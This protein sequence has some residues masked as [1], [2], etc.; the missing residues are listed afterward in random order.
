MASLTQWTWVWVNSGRLWWTGRPG[1]LRFMGSQRVGHG[2][3][4]ELTELRPVQLCSSLNIFWHFL[5]WD[6]KENW[7]VPVLWP[8]LSFPNLLEYWEQNFH[9]T[10]LRILNS[11]AGI[12]S[13]PLALFVV[14]LPK[15][16][17]TSHST[18]SGSRWVITPLWSSGS[19]RSRLY[20]FSVYYCHLVFISCAFVRCTASVLYC[21][22]RWMNYSFGISNFLEEISSLSHSIFSSLCL[23]WSLRKAFLSLLAIIWTLLSDWYIFLFSFAFLAICKAFSA[24][25]CISFSWGCFDPTCCT[26]SWTSIHSSL[27]TLSKRFNPLNLFVISAV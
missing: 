22:H 5:S 11:S 12:P 26:V 7:L 21:S 17:L 23:H 8:L 1:V 14:M 16:H 13:P 18:M 10:N 3:V 20:S 25:F 27:G 6:W 9:S 4:T 19:F 24:T 15:A 2:W